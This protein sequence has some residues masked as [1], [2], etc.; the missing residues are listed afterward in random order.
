[1]LGDRMLETVQG[2]TSKVAGHRDVAC[3]LDIVPFELE[4][5]IFCASSASC[6]GVQVL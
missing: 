3:A 2:S 6:N 1:M 4:S 5:K